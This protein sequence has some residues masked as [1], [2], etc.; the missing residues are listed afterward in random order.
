[1]AREPDPNSVRQRAF[2]LL[3][4]MTDQ[5]DWGKIRDILKEVYSIDTPYADSL[6]NAHRRI[7]R[8]TG[9][10]VDI[11]TVCDIKGG[12]PV[13]P[14]L[15]VYSTFNPEPDACLTVELAKA[16]YALHLQNKIAKAESLSIDS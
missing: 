10:M 8:T 15:K 6:I 2:S 11:Y 7:S 5:I 1:M 9:A 3:D 12:K 14:Y 16:K 13:K 4:K